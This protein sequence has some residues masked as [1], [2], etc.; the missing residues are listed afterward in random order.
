MPI[1]KKILFPIDFSETST[2]IVPYVKEIADKFEAEVHIIFSAHVTLYYEGIGLESSYIVD[3]ESEVIK[4][5]NIEFQRFLDTHFMNRPVVSK[6][7]SGQPG[8]EILRYTQNEN[9]D[10]IVMGHS[11]TGFKRMI[12]GS[13]AGYV[14]K[15][16]HVPVL[17][18]NSSTGSITTE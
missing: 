2:Q 3:F 9:I 4:K 17:I 11:K 12:M 15:K 8:E 6:I 5:G 18:V 10:L 14:V 16:S 13:V 7:L 1:F